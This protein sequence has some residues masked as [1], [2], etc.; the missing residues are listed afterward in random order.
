MSDPYDGCTHY[1]RKAMLLAPCCNVLVACRF[2][3]DKAKNEEERD[4]KKAHTMDRHAVT[5]IKCMSCNTEQ[6]AAQ[7][8]LFCSAILGAYWCPVCV[9]LDDED[10]GQYHCD[11]CGICRIG[12][13]ENHRHCDRCGICV[14]KASLENESHSCI[15]NAA[16]GDCTV[17]LES[18]HASR[19]P[20]QFLPC[21]HTMHGTCL[22]SFVKAGQHT[23][24]LCKK[25]ILGH[26]FQQHIIEQLDLEI[27]LTPMPEEYRHKRVRVLCNDCGQESD[28][29][30]H[31][32]G[33][34]CMAGCGSYNTAKIG[35]SVADA[36]ANENPS[37]E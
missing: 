18:L 32:F 34:K 9:F 16:T 17:C 3:H 1:K 30:F 23:C 8:C 10:K 13:V 33:L 37:P 35:D 26:E 28:T 21:G 11:A 12:G 24:P 14:K 31:I 19:E 20:L 2:C 5:T 4:P 6:P 25:T 15:A 27:S 22:T 29:A 36:A 7:I